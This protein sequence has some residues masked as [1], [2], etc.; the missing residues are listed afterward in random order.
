MSNSNKKKTSK[1]DGFCLFQSRNWF[2]VQTALSKQ[3]LIQFNQGDVCDLSSTASFILI[4]AIS[5]HFLYFCIFYS[6]GIHKTMGKRSHNIVHIIWRAVGWLWDFVRPDII[7]L[8]WCFLRL[9]QCWYLVSWWNEASL[10]YWQ[11][12]FYLPEIHGAA[13]AA[14]TQESELYPSAQVWW[15]QEVTSHIR[16]VFVQIRDIPKTRGRETSYTF[17]QGRYRCSSAELKVRESC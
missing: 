4:I 15:I 11:E 10:C 12:A 16:A 8:F 17:R 2:P 1:Q 5:L 7:A 6:A 13:T 14:Q 3:P 9:G